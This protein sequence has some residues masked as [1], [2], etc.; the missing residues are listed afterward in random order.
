M[1][2]GELIK[3]IYIFKYYIL[4]KCCSFEP[5]IWILKKKTGKENYF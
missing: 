2:L 4:N 5:Y 1:H 3:I